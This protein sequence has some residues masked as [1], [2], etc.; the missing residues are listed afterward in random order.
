MVRKVSRNFS[1]R[2]IVVV[3]VILIIALA[4]V[5]SRYIH[6][7][8]LEVKKE[9]MFINYTNT[10][11]ER[12]VKIYVPA[13]DNE[14]RGVATV[15]KVGIKPGSGKVLVDINNILFWLDTQQSIQTAKKVAQEV[16]KADLSKFDLIYSLENINA[17]V[18]EGP[19]AGAAL[20]IATI[21]V[22]EGKELNLKAMI[23]GTI[24]PDGSI[25]PVGGIIP[26]AQ[27]AKEVGATVFLVPE[28]QG[29]QINYIP[30]EKCEQIGYFTFCTTT[31]KKKIEN[32]GKSVGIDVVEVKN[33]KE[34]MK[35][36][37]L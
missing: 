19:S 12:F 6:V 5:S 7:E 29:T 16:T 36:F 26:K 10:T 18:V 22:I 11:Q 13:V 17:T 37:G 1:N 34:A 21:A 9:F 35:Y 8:K 15:L 2:K 23:T 20:T 28:G 4:F 33:V 14:G 27:A 25:G 3:G 32:V 31:Y 24:N 30:E